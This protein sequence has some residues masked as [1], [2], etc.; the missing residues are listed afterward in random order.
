VAFDGKHLLGV[1]AYNKVG[2]S[3]AAISSPKREDLAIVN[4]ATPKLAAFPDLIVALPAQPGGAP[5][6][7][8][9]DGER[10][11][12]LLLAEV[13]NALVLLRCLLGFRMAIGGGWRPRWSR[14]SSPWPYPLRRAFAPSLEVFSLSSLE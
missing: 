8:Y 12:D 13:E 11:G 6:G 2:V 14:F 1:E 5:L 3:A 10:L 4:L 7:V 9:F